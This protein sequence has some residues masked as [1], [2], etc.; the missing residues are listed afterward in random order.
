MGADAENYNQIL[1]GE[2]TQNVDFH[3][4]PPLELQESHR[5]RWGRSVSHSGWG[6]KENTAH[7]PQLSRAHR[8]SQTESA[9]TEPAQVCAKSSAYIICLLDWCLCGTSNSVGVGVTDFFI[10]SFLLLGS[11]TQPWYKSFLSSLIIACNAVFG[12]YSG[13][14]VLVWWEMEE[15]WNWRRGEKGCG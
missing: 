14:P 9:I 7:R 13:E 6:Y 10:C 4:V 12:G 15:N 11:P 1:E 8:D 3:W 5:N 2:G